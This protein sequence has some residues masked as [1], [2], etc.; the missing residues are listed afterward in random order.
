M[1]RLTS[2]SL[3]G[4]PSKYYFYS[5]STSAD[6]NVDVI[7]LTFSTNDPSIT[8]GTG[9]TVNVSEN[10]LIISAYEPTIIQGL[11]T[12]VS[13]DKNDLYLVINN[14]TIEYAVTLS[15]AVQNLI[16]TIN[17]PTI[18][19]P[20]NV[21]VSADL[22]M[23]SAY[24][25]QASAVIDNYIIHS[26]ATHLTITP[27]TIES[28]DSRM[29]ADYLTSKNSMG[30]NTNMPNGWITKCPTSIYGNERKLISKMISEVYKQHGVCMEYYITTYDVTYDRIFGEDND[31]RF[32]RKFDFMAYYNLPRED[33]LF[34]KFGIE[35]L[36][37]F[38]MFVSKLSFGGMS[39]FGN[40][41][42][43]GNKGKGTYSSVIP[44]IGDLVHSRFNNYFFEI[45]EVKEEQGMFLL[46]KSHIWEFI[47][48]PFKDTYISL[49][50]T[51]SASMSE[52]SPY[53]DKKTDIYNV[54]STV[55]TK[56]VNVVYVPKA[57]EEA[58]KDP[59]NSW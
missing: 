34:S 14:P 49:S 6:V 33:R 8:T 11:G 40:S 36:D 23:L 10:N 16:F 9:T 41:K 32:V 37:S 55:D 22:V 43:R 48:R 18:L 4:L 20:V 45:V 54:K 31:R 53:T 58:G 59:F 21:T 1:S 46:S 19:V 26:S 51:T 27:T 17:P 12:V 24:I 42:V 47:V 52:I 7:N 28:V 15:A 39:T 38:S 50:A 13:A 44:K 35:G 30:N 29:F 56:K 3:L 5:R 25:P 57:T 2:L